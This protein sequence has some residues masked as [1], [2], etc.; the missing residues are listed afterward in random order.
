MNN[1][2]N[3]LAAAPAQAPNAGAGQFVAGGGAT[4]VGLILLALI[5]SHW[6][7]L[8]AETKKY[9]IM[10]MLMVACLAGAGGVIGGFI[11]S[12]QTTAGTVGTTLTQTTTGQ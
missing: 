7:K 10:G 2:L 1:T 8:N 6:K 9:T 11:G 12:A 5:I 3:T 4:L